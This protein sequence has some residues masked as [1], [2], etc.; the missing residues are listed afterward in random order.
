MKARYKLYCCLLSASLSLLP[1][2][3]FAS[4]TIQ[5]VPKADEL[6]ALISVN[7]EKLFDRNDIEKMVARNK[8]ARKKQEDSLQRRYSLISKNNTASYK[9]KITILRN[10][11]DLGDSPIMNKYGEELFKLAKKQNDYKT[12]IEAIGELIQYSPGNIDN[13]RKLL[14]KIPVSNAQKEVN[15]LIAYKKVVKEF[16]QSTEKEETAALQKMIG[17]YADIP[18]SRIYDRAAKLFG[19]C[20]VMSKLST[21]SLYQEYLQEL[22]DIIKEL[23]KDG[24]RFLPYAYHALSANLYSK[25]DLQKEGYKIDMEMLRIEKERDSIYKSEGRIYKS[26]ELQRYVTYRRMIRYSSILSSEQI[27]DLY[28]K[29]TEIT[30]RNP[31]LYMEFHSSSSICSIRY[32]MAMKRYKEAIP[33][34]N[35]VLLNK[36]KQNALKLQRECLKDIIFAKLELD[37]NADIQEYADRY[38]DLLDEERKSTLDEKNNEMQI[39]YNIDLLEQNSNKK[40][41]RS[42]ITYLSIVIALFALTFYMLIHSRSLTNGL[43]ESKEKLLKEKRELNTRMK[44]LDQAMIKAE[45]AAKLKTAFIQNMEH[46]IR[47]PLNAIVG[48]SKIMA[49]PGNKI[50]EGEEAKFK[51]IINQ[52]TAFLN[53]IVTDIL[54]ITNLESGEMNY[55]IAPEDINDIC[56]FVVSIV[57][58]RAAAGVKMYFKNHD[59]TFML[60]TDKK[61]LTQA[62]LN[63]LTNSCKFTQEGSIVLDYE[64]TNHPVD[65]ID[66]NGC[67]VFSV[68]D[69]GIGV[70]DDKA[71]LIF[72][73]F[74][75]L[76]RFSQGP[77]L[78]LYICRLIANGLH[79]EVKLD[80]TYSGGSKFLLIHPIN[81]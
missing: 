61:R 39:L 55:Q 30:N 70:P 71:D 73:R 6:Q 72:N 80:R 69:T 63:F 28:D 66:S 7:G 74:E 56:N 13:Y 51:E 25:K 79:G 20:T 8:L 15:A 23:P 47:T 35:N 33:L 44:T 57:K 18:E 3:S 42:G 27:Q 19:L 58:G 59:S 78:G 49:D 52:N 41:I 10:I 67:V 76:N 36:K 40:F 46:E 50:E 22:G 68:T 60:N 43:K 77:G 53:T 37:K 62:L 4:V 38:I 12:E 32:L 21:N 48:F 29:L 31:A 65:G 64:I 11:I 16:S 54:D 26:A 34:L 81:L 14:S 75:K 9:E 5:S 45:N 24:R 2:V 17:E 1:L